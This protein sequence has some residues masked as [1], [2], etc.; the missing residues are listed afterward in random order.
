MSGRTYL[1][2]LPWVV[3]ALVG[4]ALSEGL[5]WGGAAALITAVVIAVASARTGSV[6]LLEISAIVLFAGFVVVGASHQ[7]DPHGFLQQYC[8]ALSAGGLA[9]TALV[10]LRSTP[11]TEPYARE[12]VPRKLWTTPRFKRVNVDLTLTWAMVFGAIA[13]SNAA[14][15]AIDTRLWETV[16]NW[17]VPVALTLVGVKQASLQWSEQFDAQAMG[18]DAMLGQIEFW[19]T[20]R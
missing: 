16:F 13:L 18:L 5:A 4:P 1:G 8:C 19:E 17:L 20:I 2:F 6:K 3:F 15:A 11:V 9:L 12:I 7:H 10:S 14:G